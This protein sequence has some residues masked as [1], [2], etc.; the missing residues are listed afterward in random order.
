MKL[1][2]QLNLDYLKAMPRFDSYLDLYPTTQLRRALYAIHDDLIEF[3][4]AC[5]EFLNRNVLGNPLSFYK[6]TKSEHNLTGICNKHSP[7]NMVHS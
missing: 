5:A 3:C 6:T 1:F 2:D 7:P 4:L